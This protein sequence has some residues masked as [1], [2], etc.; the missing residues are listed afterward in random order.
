MDRT[1]YGRMWEQ[2][3]RKRLP[4]VGEVRNVRKSGET[5][6]ESLHIAPVRGSKGYFLEIRP[7]GNADKEFEDAFRTFFS[8]AA[9]AD[10]FRR[11]SLRWTGIDPGAPSAGSLAGYLEE[12]LVLPTARRFEG[13]AEDAGLVAD[14]QRDPEA[15]ALLFHKYRPVVRN[16]FLYRLEGDREQA[17]DLCQETFLRALSALPAYASRNAAY[18]TYLLRIAHN[19]LVDHYRKPRADAL[20]DDIPSNGTGRLS[21]LRV[22]FL[23]GWGRLGAKERRCLELF[24]WEGA[25]IREIAAALGKSENAVKLQLSRARKRLRGTGE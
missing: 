17:D 19:L 7:S 1:F 21:E 22:R 16:Y 25:S 12:A 23:R 18:R 4:F 10:G 8:H 2:I 6:R 3:S 11:F 9:S 15:F 5:Q 24:H 13:R 20:S 14:A